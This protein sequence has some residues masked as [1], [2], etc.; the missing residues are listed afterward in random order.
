M[1]CN[2][3]LSHTHTFSAATCQSPKT[4]TTCGATEGEKLSEHDTT[5]GKCSMCGLDYFDELFKIINNSSFYSENT[6]K[7]YENTYGM[8]RNAND[9]NNRYDY[10]IN[11]ENDNILRLCCYR[12]IPG[13][14]KYD[15]VPYQTLI[16]YI[17]RSSVR[18]QT[19]DYRASERDVYTIWKSVDIEGE[20]EAVDFSPSMVLDYEEYEGGS[21]SDASGVAVYAS[22]LLR[23]AITEMIIPLLEENGLTISNYGFELFE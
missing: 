1:S 23:D 21:Q 19:Y 11:I 20:I 17:T 14:F 5:D 12:F 18:K 16:V 7:E 22:Q 8:S 4:C 10:E 3:N 15:N 6:K 13:L 9:N 2:S